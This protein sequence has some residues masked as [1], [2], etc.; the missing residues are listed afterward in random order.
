MAGAERETAAAQLERRRMHRS[1]RFLLRMSIFLGLVAALIR[2]A[3]RGAEPP[4]H[5]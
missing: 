4:A 2:D 5:G 3:L 1:H